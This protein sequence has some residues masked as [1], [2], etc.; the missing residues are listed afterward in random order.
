MRS[1]GTPPP[2]VSSAKKAAPKG[3]PSELASD[4]AMLLL[5][6]GV[7]QILLVHG[8]VGCGGTTVE[9]DRSGR[10][11]CLGLCHM[12]LRGESGRRRDG[13]DRKTNKNF[14]HHA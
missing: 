7:V 13:D 3:R 10:G 9:H 12:L 2:V 6:P 14:L 4:S 1:G 11:R 5:H 8:L